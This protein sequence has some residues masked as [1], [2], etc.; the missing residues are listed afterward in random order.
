MTSTITAAS[1]ANDDALP[2]KGCLKTHK[3]GRDAIVTGATS[4]VLWMDGD[5]AIMRLTPTVGEP[6]TLRQLIRALQCGYLV[7]AQRACRWGEHA[8]VVAEHVA[9]GC[10]MSTDAMPHTVDY[11]PNWKVALGRDMVVDGYEARLG[12][13]GRLDVMLTIRGDQTQTLPQAA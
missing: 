13:D 5:N 12:E 11:Q 3:V 4:V 8:G 6:L 7:S 2:I 10:R 1:I 9:R